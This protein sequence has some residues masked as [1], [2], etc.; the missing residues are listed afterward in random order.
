M[1]DQNPKSL[2]INVVDLHKRLDDLETLATPD[3]NAEDSCGP[4]LGSFVCQ[5]C[6]ICTLCGHCGSA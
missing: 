6:H 1:A 4:L 5:P 2:D 3:K